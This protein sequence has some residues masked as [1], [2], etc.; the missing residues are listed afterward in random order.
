[1]GDTLFDVGALVKNIQLEP[2]NTLASNLAAFKNHNNVV[3]QLFSHYIEK[4]GLSVAMIEGYVKRLISLKQTQE[5]MVMFERL[6][7]FMQG[8]KF[9]SEKKLSPEEQIKLQNEFKKRNAQ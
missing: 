7:L 6:K 8:R 9:H 2:L 3:F 1:M 5:F 4:N